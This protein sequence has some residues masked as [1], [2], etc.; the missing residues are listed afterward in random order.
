MISQRFAVQ[1]ADL[2]Q[3]SNS[4]SRQIQYRHRLSFLTT[5]NV[6]LIATADYFFYAQ[7]AGWTEAA[8]AVLITGVMVLA[9]PQKLRSLIGVSLLLLLL[10]LV[11]ALASQPG[12]LV[13]AITILALITLSFHD[14]SWKK[15]NLA[16]LERWFQFLLT[17]WM[18]LFKDVTAVYRW[19]RVH[20]QRTLLQQFSIHLRYWTLP[21]LLSLVFLA[22]FNAA[23]PVIA[24]WLRAFDQFL[25]M[26]FGDINIGIGRL[27]FWLFTG[28]WIWALLRFKNS[29][30][31]NP[32]QDVIGSIRFISPEVLTRCLILF[33]IL[34]AV[35]TILD[36]V[37]LWSGFSLPEGMTYAQYA[38]RGAYPLIATALMAGLF[39]LLT[40][41]S[42]RLPA[43]MRAIKYMVYL[44]LGQNILL[45]FSALWRLTLYVEVY[46]LTL[47]RTAAIIWMFVVA[48]GLLSI[49]IRILRSRSNRWLVNA[50]LATTLFV[51]YLCCFFNFDGFIA[52]YNVRH[53]REI[54]G[55]GVNLDQAYL[56][57]LGYESIPALLWFHSMNPEM[58]G[59][60]EARANAVRL[61]DGLE[62]ETTNWRAWTYRKHEL[63]KKASEYGIS[64]SL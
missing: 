15:S 31:V 55:K 39:V 16:W 17:G 35:E 1:T 49:L 23:N 12:P 63:R 13:R 10:G 44:W 14:R 38:H 9:N 42:G 11:I 30:R 25:A 6:A 57:H 56:I 34:F 24:W 32:N 29:I 46:S 4:A 26:A 19:K 51:L 52:H 22:L 41:R 5:V 62:K 27:T 40:F 61:A 7:P 33:N 64:N 48:A 21:V 50:N 59:G 3:N 45:T 8:Y 20:Q 18:K 36:A 60:R 2:N 58:A 43:E 54:S 47:L 28:V 37:Y 53:S